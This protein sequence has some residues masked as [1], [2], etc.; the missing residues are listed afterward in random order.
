LRTSYRSSAADVSEVLVVERRG[1]KKMKAL[2]TG[3]TGFMGS[4]IVRELMKDGV[5]VRVLVRKTSDT[6]NIDGLDV[7]KL[8]GDVLDGESVRMAL[9]GCDTLYHAA[10][11]YAVWVPNPKV[12]YDINVE[13]TKNVLGAARQAGVRKVVYTSSAAT[14]GAHGKDSPATE[15]AEFNTWK[16]GE[17]YSRSKYLAEAEAMK[18]CQHGLPLVVVNPAMVIGVRDAR[19]TPSGKMILDVVNRKMPGY[20][21]GGLNLV[22]VEDVARG[23]VLA[24]QKG[25][26]GER[27]ILG[28]ENMP[29]SDYFKLIAEVAGVKPPGLKIPYPMAIVLGYLFGAIARVTKRPPVITAPVVR[30][31]SKYAYF[32]SSKAVN[33]L[34]FTQTPIKTTVEKAISWYR[35]N[36][37]VKVA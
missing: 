24:A 16:M 4:S 19:P 5:E 6:R 28:N 29:V 17:H 18:F 22:D 7:E 13:G 8:H 2:V 27:Y 14:L 25:R 36:G 30:F 3:A 37:Y 32:D 21:E 11:L 31:G 33:E 9:G 35:E 23:H 12:L 15:E 26:I 20:I 34:G 10:A 1:G